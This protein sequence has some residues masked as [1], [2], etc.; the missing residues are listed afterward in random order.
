[1]DKRIGAHEAKIKLPKLLRRV[2]AGEH[3]VITNRGRPIAELRPVTSGTR[4]AARDSVAD[5]RA[6]PK[7]R[8]VSARMLR[9]L[10]EEGRL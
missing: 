8:G 1:M 3:F 6:L 9:E 4:I 7:I 2:E 10:I 5:M